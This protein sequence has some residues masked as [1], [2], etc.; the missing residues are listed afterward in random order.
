MHL[1]TGEVGLGTVQEETLRPGKED[2]VARA[3]AGGHVVPMVRKQKDEGLL[4]GFLLFPQPRT[5]AMRWCSPQ[6]R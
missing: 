4:V 5:P 1:K 2:M 6:S 3:R